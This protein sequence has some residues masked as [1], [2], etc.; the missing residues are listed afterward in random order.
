MSNE[1]TLTNEEMPEAVKQ[2][3]AGRVRLKE[4]LPGDHNEIRRRQIVSAGTMVTAERNG[5][6]KHFIV[7][8]DG[9]DDGQLIS[10]AAV[11]RNPGTTDALIQDIDDFAFGSST[12]RV[13]RLEVMW[14]VFRNEGL[15]NNGVRK[16][17]ALI[18]KS[19]EFKVSKAKKG[20]KQKAKEQL[21]AVLREFARKVN[22]STTDG[23]ITGY[24]GLQALTYRAV[25]NTLVEG[26]WF[27][28]EHWINH[29]VP[30][31]GKFSLPMTIQS[32]SAR[33]ITTDENLIGVASQWYWVPPSNLINTLTSPN[34]T[35]KDVVKK[36]I[37]PKLVNELKSQRR[38]LLDNSLLLHLQHLGT[39]DVAYGESFI[40]PAMFAVAY[41]RAVENL[42]LVSIKNLIN[43]LVILQVG[44]SDK[45][46]PYRDPNTQLLRA[47]KMVEMV[48][49][50]GP[51]MLLVWQGD[52]VTVTQV[53]AHQ[54]VL[55]L[56]ERH[57]V[58]H[59]K[60]RLS[61]GL[62]ESLLGGTEDGSK[63]S[64]FAALLG[65]QT[66]SD[67]LR[68]AVE[69][70]YTEL[71]EK[72]AFENGF[73]DFEISFA[74]DNVSSLDANEEWNQLRLDY[75]QGTCSIRHYLQATGKDADAM[76]LEMLQER[77][78]PPDTLWREAFSPPVG[79]PGQAVPPG[80]DPGGKAP[81]NRPPDSQ[82]RSPEK[83]RPVKNQ[84]EE[85]S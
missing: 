24:R 31:E 51:N 50:P 58:G 6:G 14:R 8:A 15:I 26:D 35:Q 36:F 72:I 66:V 56:N 33:Y 49:D 5:W 22:A 38:V 16:M 57:N 84:P 64:G 71:G 48:E 77:G 62:P 76:Y 42:D 81:T 41:K 29:E 43:R 80:R 54:S 9:E 75:Q 45:D 55:D 53:S 44:N 83:E 18:A 65:A 74:F 11:L 7:R 28:R 25:R 37:D 39:E 27:G 70:M 60:V 17:S 10:V 73:T 52:D 82:T 12:D 30:G 46:S 79:L 78:L 1:A 68:A 34:K 47:N 69:Q 19:G 21:E 3:M 40:G 63:A 23:T 13:R 20:K 85:L 4:L 2:L 59:T 61:L 32:I 67:E